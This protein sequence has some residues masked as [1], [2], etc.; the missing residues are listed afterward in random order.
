MIYNVRRSVLM[1]TSCKTRYAALVYAI[2]FNF[3][4]VDLYEQF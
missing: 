2:D 1:K 4:W 3:D